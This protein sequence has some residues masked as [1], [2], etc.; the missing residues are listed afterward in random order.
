MDDQGASE[1]TSDALRGGVD[2]QLAASRWRPVAAG[3]VAHGPGN[4]APRPWRSSAGVRHARALPDG[5]EQRLGRNG[6][7]GGLGLVLVDALDHAA[8]DPQGGVDKLR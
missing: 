7:A 3:W 8:L 4:L 6:S 1:R 5:V 2:E